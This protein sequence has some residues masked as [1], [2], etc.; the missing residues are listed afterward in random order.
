M[1]E[2]LSLIDLST[3]PDPIAPQCRLCA[4]SAR[5]LANR[6]QWGM[7]CNGYNC[8]N[9]ERLCSNC[10]NPFIQGTDG[11]G[12]KYCST[13]CKIV[14]YHP[15]ALAALNRPHCAWCGTGEYRR[16]N[17][18]WPYICRPCLDPI[19]HV[20]DRLKAHHVPHERAHQ[21]LTDPGC[22]ICGTN[23]LTTIRE[24]GHGSLRSVLVVDHDH[25]CC[26]AGKT[27]C[28]R[29]VRGLICRGC[30]SAA[31][32]LSDDPNTARALGNY[33]DRWFSR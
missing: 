5:W 14:G 16:T 25:N 13:Q 26:P 27:S 31:G 3:A 32:L 9:R 19:K 17:A 15:K 4:R 21:L 24:G 12:T 2:Q 11:A 23:L 20:V 22:E 18:L 6:N 10:G 33:L 29:C 30:N 8:N 28:G 1:T 7:Y